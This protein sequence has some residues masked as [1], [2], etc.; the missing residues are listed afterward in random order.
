MESNGFYFKTYENFIKDN[1]LLKEPKFYDFQKLYVVDKI[2][3]IKNT[4]WSFLE[5]TSENKITLITCVDGKPENRLCVQAIE[6]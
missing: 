2:E 4:D 5:N 3:I 6:K 1:G